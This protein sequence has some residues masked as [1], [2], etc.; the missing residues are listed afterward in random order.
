MLFAL[1]LVAV[2]SAQTPAKPTLVPTFTANVSLVVDALGNGIAK[3]MTGTIYYD[4]IGK[5]SRMDLASSYFD[6]DFE[7]T[8]FDSANA[9]YSLTNGVCRSFSGTKAFSSYF[10]W[11]GFATYNGS[12]TLNGQACNNWVFSKGPLTLSA[13]CDSSFCFSFTVSGSARPVE[14]YFTGNLAA[15]SAPM[16]L[17]KACLAPPPVCPKNANAWQTMDLFRLHNVND[18]TLQQRNTA[19]LIGDLFYICAALIA[20]PSSPIVANDTVVS[21]FRLNL[22]ST[23]GQY[24]LCNHDSCVGGDDRTVGHEAT[25]GFT[26]GGGQCMMHSAIGDWFSLTSSSM[27]AQN[28]TVPSTSCA[29]QLVK[30]I[31]SVGMPCLVSAGLVAACH[32]DQLSGGFPFAQSARL[33]SKAIQRGCPDVPPPRPWN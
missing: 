10:S 25:S 20:N 16:K 17:P 6:Q 26:V 11:L 33:V 8:S 23:W 19:T 22:N 1:L 24:A 15:V 21:T 7:Y 9:S 4:E 28:A 18:T 30:R 29:W 31:K 12:T 13:C 3:A 2:C 27:C 32:A 5:Q 14:I